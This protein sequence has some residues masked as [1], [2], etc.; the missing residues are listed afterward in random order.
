MAT[1]MYCPECKTS[2]EVTKKGFNK[3]KEQLYIC[4]TCGKKFTEADGTLP[5][6]GTKVKAPKKEVTPKA[7]PAP[8]APKFKTSIIVNNNIIKV[9]EKELTIDQA[10]DLVSSYF[11]E[12]AK[13][14]VVAT[15]KN[16]EKTIKF[17]V[18]AGTKG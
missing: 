5:V 7:P 4:K 15:E 11:K 6:S 8:S 13:E 1:L 2:R 16:G 18:N 9:V 10:F 12:I 14:K 3:A 17:A